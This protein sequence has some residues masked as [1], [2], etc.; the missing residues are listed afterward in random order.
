MKL[1]KFLISTLLI[2]SIILSLVSCGNKGAQVSTDT[3]TT[4]QITE[5]TM[6]TTEAS[7]SATESSA[8]YNNLETVP[9]STQPEQTS[10]G[11]NTT[12]PEIS[13]AKKLESGVSVFTSKQ[14]ILNAYNE[15]VNYAK[16]AE[17][18]YSKVE[19]QEIPE[20]ERML[21]G[22]VANLIL[23]IASNFMRSKK[24]AEAKPDT[25]E[26][27]GEMYWFP[28]YGSTKGCLLTDAASIVKA[29]CIKRSDGNYELTFTLCDEIN[30]QPTIEFTDTPRS[31][32][33]SVFQ[34]LE[35]DD[36][37]KTLKEDKIVTKVITGVDY[38][39][40]YYNC[41]VVLVYNPETKHIVTLD[42][43]MHTLV[44]IKSAKVLL[45]NVSGTA[46]LDNTLKIYNFQY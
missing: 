25:T 6:H 40:T 27:G 28:I 36:L 34:P 22:W 15:V 21:E 46:V 18:G 45:S 5:T 2:S 43:Y 8:Q 10:A 12:A 44:D 31:V 37:N 39:L 9:E 33:G 14:E 32:V 20:S 23:P 17:P 38:E 1:K 29:D 4:T 26:K 11:S 16:T 41:N 3:E 30:S 35:L 42:H 24:D 7:Y 19:Y 13:T